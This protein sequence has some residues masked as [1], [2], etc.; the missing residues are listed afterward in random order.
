MNLVFR[1]VLVA[2][3]VEH[4]V[5]TVVLDDVRRPEVD[6]VPQLRRHAQGERLLVPRLLK[7]LFRRGVGEVD[8]VHRVG[9]L[10]VRN[11]KQAPPPVVAVHEAMVVDVPFRLFADAGV[12]D[13]DEVACLDQF[14][15]CRLLTARA[16]ENEDAHNDRHCNS[17]AHFRLP[18]RFAY[19]STPKLLC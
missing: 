5:K 4:V 1:V 11:A 8:L 17:A 12:V 7:Q 18:P 16:S 15:F 10:A 14:F 19:A 6:F 9:R 3:A 2:G 13:F